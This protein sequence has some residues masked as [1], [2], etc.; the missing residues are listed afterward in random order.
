MN[1]VII[2]AGGIGK[3]MGGNLPKQFL[4][5]SGKPILMHTIERFHNYDPQLQILLTL[6]ADWLDYWKQCC[7][8]HAFD[9]AHEVVSGGVERYHS[10]Q[11]ALQ[12][13]TGSLIGVHDGVRPLVSETTISACF[14]AAETHGSGIPCIPISESL[15]EQT[16]SGS[17]AVNRANYLIVQTPQCFRSE[18]LKAAY[19]QP[20]HVGITDDASLVE[21]SGVTVY[22]VSGNRENIKIT[23]PADV[24]IAGLFI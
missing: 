7:A 21:E 18:I 6:P 10:I 4:L 12:K 1:T 14:S 20:Y 5:L 9:I 13:A 8:E 22:L 17:R 11:L 23:H 16:P 15:R 24:R 19:Q 3:R 2:T